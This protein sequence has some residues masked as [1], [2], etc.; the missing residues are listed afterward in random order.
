MKFYTLE[1]HHLH[2]ITI[3]YQYPVFIKVLLIE[4]L[5]LL[6]KI[7]CK[8]EEFDA[9]LFSHIPTANRAGVNYITAH[10]RVSATKTKIIN[11]A[12]V[13]N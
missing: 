13:H 9:S 5:T 6:Q 8:Y 2:G 11:T 1:I 3:M 10:Q 4:Y 7:S 12:L